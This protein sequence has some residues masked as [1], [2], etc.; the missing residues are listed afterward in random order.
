MREKTIKAVDKSK[1]LEIIC[2]NSGG[3]KKTLLHRITQ[4]KTLLSYVVCY[5][6]QISKELNMKLL[7]RCLTELM[8]R[9]LKALRMILWHR[10]CK[11]ALMYRTGNFIAR[12]EIAAGIVDTVEDKSLRWYDGA[13][14]MAT[15]DQR[16]I[17]LL[18]TVFRM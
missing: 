11:L 5:T 17:I 9:K 6:I 8:K 13:S 10:S 15:H 18:R 2:D 16:V 4:A 14:R 3:R 12:I 7:W 1:C